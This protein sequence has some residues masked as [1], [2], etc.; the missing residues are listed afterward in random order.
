DE[1]FGLNSDNDDYLP[2]LSDKYD[3]RVQDPVT[4]ATE[5]RN[6][7]IILYYAANERGK[8]LGNASLPAAKVRDRDYIYFSQDNEVIAKQSFKGATEADYEEN[9]FAFINDENA[10][11][12]NTY[13]PYNPES[14]LLISRGYDG[15]YGTDD[16]VTN[17][18]D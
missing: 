9:F 15:I 16:D 4:S 3:K 1:I 5:Y 14:F 12:G 10:R 17:W 18:G 8:Y 7:S 2:L 6:H 11:V 13:R